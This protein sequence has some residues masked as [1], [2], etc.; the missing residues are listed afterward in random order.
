MAIVVAGISVIQG[1]VLAKSAV[2]VSCP[3][4]TT[5]DILATISVPAGAMGISGVLRI[6][7]EW[8]WTNSAN[9][10]TLRIRY[11]GTDLISS[12]VLTTT[13]TGSHRLSI[14]NRGA[15][16]S[17]KHRAEFIF[18]STPPANTNVAFATSGTLSVDTTA[19]SSIV[20]SGQ[21]AL[22][23]EVLTLESYLVELFPSA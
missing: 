4:D 7:V 6:Y 1:Y 17:Q 10:K 11:G 9:N 12:T 15:T 14:F 20:F 18:G 22:A 16:N 19:L 21:K 13:A 5:E 23:G 2:A 8:T 3:A